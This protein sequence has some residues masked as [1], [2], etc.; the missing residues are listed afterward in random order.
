MPAMLA[1]LVERR[2]T[3]KGHLVI[4]LA[5]AAICAPFVAATFLAPQSG[6]TLL[7]AIGFVAGPIALGT[8]LACR[9]PLSTLVA[10][11]IGL[12]PIDFL[13]VYSGGVTISR[14]IGFLA[15]GAMVLTIIVRG[16]RL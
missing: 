6:T 14:L 7:L 8:W 12:P 10:L 15:V 1:Q 5:A 2:R 13:L 9:R 4:G 3:P 11:Y 16:S